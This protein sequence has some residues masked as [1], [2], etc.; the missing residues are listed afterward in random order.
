MIRRSLL[1][2][3]ALSVLAC[4]N[5]SN[6]D[7]RTRIVD[8]YVA[9]LR[10]C[11]LLSKQG[12]FSY[13]PGEGTYCATDCLAKANCDDLTEFDC[14]EGEER[15][16]ESLDSCF[17]G[18][19]DAPRELGSWFEC[20]DGD[21]TE[22]LY[23]DGWED[24][25]DGSDEED[26]PKSVAFTCKD[27]VLSIGS[28]AECDGH[29]D[30][31]DG[32]DEVRCVARGLSFQCKDGTEYISKSSVCDGWEECEDGSDEEQGCATHTCQ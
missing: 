3:A 21:D 17:E 23:C 9:K 26:C 10:E 2:L 27:D 30:C 14:N 20:E 24:C 1:L 28:D 31:E 13:R 6:A 5:D 32:S 29:E 22:A 7:R 8:R 4:A 15:W 16:S 11:G 18:C 25:E 12:K 19:A